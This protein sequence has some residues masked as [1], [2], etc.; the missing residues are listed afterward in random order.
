MAWIY[1]LLLLAA[2]IPL[3]KTIGFI[4]LEEKIRKSG[5][6]TNG[7]VIDIHTTRYHRGP[8]T[9][10]VQV[11]YNSNIAGQYHEASFV[12]KHRQYKRG[13]TIP[14]QYLPEKP[15][16]IIVSPKRGYWIMLIFSILLF[17]FCVYA[18]FG[19]N[20]ML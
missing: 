14:V 6:V 15:G 20:E 4:I 5:I 2:S 8:V 10:R 18:V 1:I 17:L 19:I 9:D 3:W 13:Q 16:K 12:A 11:R 7:M